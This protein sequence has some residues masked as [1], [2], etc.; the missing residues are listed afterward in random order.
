MTSER[1]ETAP[2]TVA[3]SAMLL[4]GGSIAGPGGTGGDL[5]RPDHLI[6][7]SETRAGR[8]A[9]RVCSRTGDVC[10]RVMAD[11]RVRYVVIR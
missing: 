6:V 10:Y 8:L 4:S 7:T 5:C 11:G 3:D 9:G 1:D 2:G